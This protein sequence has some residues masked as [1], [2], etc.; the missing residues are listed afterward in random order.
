MTLVVFRIAALAI[1]GAGSFEAQSGAPAAL[2]G[3]P[4]TNEVLN[5]S[6]NWPSGITL[7]EAHLRATRAG[8]NWDF[9]FNLDAG[10]PGFEV[11]DLYRAS[12]GSNLCSIS[13]DRST[14]HGS[15]KTEEKENVDSER[16]TVSRMTGSGGGQS[17]IPV[18]SCIRDA[19]AYLFYTRE[20]MGQGRVPPAQQILFGG[21]YQVSLSYAGA[22]MI[23][24]GGKQ[25]QSDELNCTVKGPSSSAAFEVYFARDAAR[26][27]LLVKVPFAM[28]TFSMELVR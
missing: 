18:P 1:L 13:F 23:P 21:L 27:P 9:S 17:S 10:I 26:T 22:P 8:S 5:Y 7:G 14:L 19:L 12:A 2:T 15:R 3:F 6:V 4:F 16:G 24:V 25:V 20:E 28:G 11:K